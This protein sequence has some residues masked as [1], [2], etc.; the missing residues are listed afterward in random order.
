MPLDYVSR[1]AA[2]DTTEHWYAASSDSYPAAERAANAAVRPGYEQVIHAHSHTG[3]CR[4]LSN[5]RECVR[6]RQPEPA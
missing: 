1:P 2:T 4:D 5:Y 6:L 3:A